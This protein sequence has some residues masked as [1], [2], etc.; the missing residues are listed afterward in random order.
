MSMIREVQKE[1]HPWSAEALLVKSQRYAEQMHTYV[2]DDWKFILWS[3]LALELLARAALSHISPTLLADS[4]D[5]NNILYSLE[6]EPKVAKF[7]PRSIDISA[8]FLRLQGLVD[9]F[10]PELTG[11]SVTHLSRR[12]DELHS[13]A[14]P[15][16][17][18]SASVWLP[19]FYR[20]C[21]VLLKSMDEDL[22]YY[23]GDVRAA[24][25][26]TMIA[27]SLDESAK[28]I[29]KAIHGSTKH[30]EE[31]DKEVRDQLKL[32]AIAWATK[33]VGHRIECPACKCAAIVTG[34]P[35]AA[36]TRSIEED[37]ITDV[38]EYLPS[39][40]ECIACGLKMAG[41]PHLA[42]AGIGDPFKATFTYDATELYRSSEDPY[43]G[44]EP[45]YND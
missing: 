17:G 33:H 28:A 25:A 14:T 26:Q 44:Y 24:A 15:L 35:I 18:I 4:K 29:G 21:E 20:A 42:A 3:T 19:M 2:H 12:N 37:E 27:A 34:S 7:A 39:R 32:Q 9:D 1:P 23:L 22:D 40:F 36:P 30:W 5:W 8:V 10:T 41:L 16:D 11:F 45:D 31:M 43:A 13:G 6:R 38:Q